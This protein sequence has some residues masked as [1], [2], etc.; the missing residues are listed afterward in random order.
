[1]N[2]RIV[3]VTGGKRGIGAAVV[4]AFLAQGSL[5]IALDRDFS[6]GLVR[7]EASQDLYTYRGDVSQPIEVQA[8]T[9][10]LQEFGRV[11]VLVNNAGI[12]IFKPLED[13]EIDEW[14]YVLNTNLR[15]PFLM[16]KFLLPLLR[17]GQNPSIINI[18]STR[19]FQSEPNTE[20]YSASKGGVVALTHSLAVSLS[21]YGIRVNCISPGWIETNPDAELT[22]EDHKQHLVGRVGVPSDIAHACVYLASPEAGFIT[23]TNLTID[24]GMT[25]KMIY[26]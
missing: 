19:A 26:V 18:A 5:V 15:G 22:N 11:D 14:N 20:S 24:G 3:V 17:K 6:P 7:S 21:R 1:M 12:G 2:K 16:T 23:G 13:L 8:F 25:V 9:E 4:D 10:V